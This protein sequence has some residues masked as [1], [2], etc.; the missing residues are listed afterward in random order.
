M[1]LK[2]INKELTDLGRDPPP[3]A[4][5]APSEMIWYALRNTLNALT[6]AFPSPFLPRRARPLLAAALSCGGAESV[7]SA[8]RS[9]GK[10]PLWGDSPYSGGVFFLTIHF[11]TDYPFKPP[12]VNF[13]TRI[14]HPNINSNGSICLDILRDQWSPALTISKVLLS[15]CSML[16]DPN[17]DDPLVPEIAHVYKTDRPRYEATAR[18]WTRKY[19]I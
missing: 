10:Q 8:D 18:E 11:P 5:L 13:T 17:P 3:P 4:P 2:R 1:A 12:K 19:A 7:P 6:L 9:T 16:T 14:Y 15:I